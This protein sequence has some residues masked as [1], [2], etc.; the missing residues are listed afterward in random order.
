MLN[1]SNDAIR[2]SIDTATCGQ[3]MSHTTTGLLLTVKY[4]WI[5][6]L[7]VSLEQINETESRTNQ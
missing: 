2:G 3:Y 7:K 4:K 6:S 5:G 1:R